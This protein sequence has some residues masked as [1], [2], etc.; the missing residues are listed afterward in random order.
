MD[1]LADWL[2]G[3]DYAANLPSPNRTGVFLRAWLAEE[4]RALRD[5]EAHKGARGRALA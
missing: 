5:Y 3:V 2:D 1:T 4:P